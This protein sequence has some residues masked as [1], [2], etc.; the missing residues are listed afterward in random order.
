[1]DIHYLV[2]QIQHSGEVHVEDVR[3]ENE[4]RIQLVGHADDVVVE[5]LEVRATSRL[6]EIADVAADERGRD[7]A[8]GRDD[9]AD[10][11]QVALEP[12]ELA[13]RGVRVARV[14]VDDHRLDEFDAVTEPVEDVE[15]GVDDRVED[16]VQQ[17]ARAP[18]LPVTEALLDLL[19]RGKR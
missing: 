10:R 2:E 8:F 4:E 17:Q 6:A 11:E 14:A 1:L 3:N 5:I 18:D 7:V 16:R 19:E 13:D 9:P 15:V 12:E